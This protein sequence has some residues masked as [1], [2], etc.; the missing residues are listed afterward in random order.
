MT[1]KA[2]PRPVV[3]CGPA[4]ATENAEAPRTSWDFKNPPPE[5]QAALDRHVVFRFPQAGLVSPVRASRTIV[6]DRAYKACLRGQL[7]SNVSF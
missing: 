6:A 4:T 5:V 7:S 3:V 2:K 1:G